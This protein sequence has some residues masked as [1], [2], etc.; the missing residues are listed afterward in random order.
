MGSDALIGNLDSQRAH[1]RLGY[2]EVE[3]L[4]VFRKN[5]L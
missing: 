5:L 4:V 1:L 2:A 3:R